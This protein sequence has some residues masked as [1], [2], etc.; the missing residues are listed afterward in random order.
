MSTGPAPDCPG[1]S[2]R[3]RHQGSARRRDVTGGVMLALEVV[4]LPVADTDRAL[5][6]YTA[7]AG[8]TVGVD[9]RPTQ[10]F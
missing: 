8:F 10:D 6:F 7:Q 5:A 3:D 4:S 1:L 9:Y 2:G